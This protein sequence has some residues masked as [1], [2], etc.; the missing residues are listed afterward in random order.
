MDDQRPSTPSTRRPEAKTAPGRPAPSPVGA[1][2][3]RLLVQVDRAV[4]EG[5]LLVVAGAGFGKTELLAQWFQTRPTTGVMWLA[6]GDPTP[7]ASWSGAVVVDCGAEPA[8]GGL[9]DHDRLWRL[10]VLS[11][12]EPVQDL[13]LSRLNGRVAL[14]DARG[15]RMDAKEVADA[16]PWVG[17]AGVGRIMQLTGGWPLAVEALARRLPRDDPEGRRTEAVLRD[18][19]SVLADYCERQVFSELSALDRDRLARLSIATEVDEALAGLLVGDGE[20]AATIALGVRIGLLSRAPDRIARWR[21]AHPLIASQLQALARERRPE[22]LLE[23]HGAA[24]TWLAQRGEDEAAIRHAFEARD[25]ALLADL[26]ERAG[27]WRLAIDWR[28][29]QFRR[30]WLQ[31]ILDTLPDGL[32]ET[33]PGLRLARIMAR[34][35]SGEA[36]LAREDYERLA[37][38]S[39]V[40]PEGTFGLDVEIV[41]H[42]IRMLEESPPSDDQKAALERTAQRIPM[43]DG[44]ASATLDNALCLATLQRGEVEEALDAGRRSCRA[45]GWIGSRMNAAVVQ[46]ALGRACSLGAHRMAAIR[47]YQD[48]LATCA[49]ELGEGSDLARC[50][51]VLL[52][53]EA[54]S[55]NQVPEARAHLEGSMSWV[56]AQ[57]PQFHAPAF[58]TSA[59]LAVH[60]GDVEAGA[61]IIDSC[62][63][64]AQRRGLPRLELSAQLC[65]LEQL[66]L[67]GE[68]EAA[69]TLAGRIG[70]DGTCDQTVDRLLAIDARLVA[71]RIDIETDAISTALSHLAVAGDLIAERPAGL[72]QLNHGVLHAI[73]LRAAGDAPAAHAQLDAI[74]PTIAV[75]GLS[76][77]FLDRGALAMAAL[78]DYARLRSVGRPAVNHVLDDFMTGVLADSRRERHEHRSCLDGLPLTEREHQIA[79]CLARGLSNKEIGRSMQISG[80]TVKWHL[81]NL[82]KR[83]DVESRDALVTR[84]NESRVSRARRSVDTGIASFRL[85]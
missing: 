6:P 16:A 44:L 61:H 55:G 63:R 67:I 10:I 70:L 54:F 45:Y 26:L 69:A 56:E 64:A 24:A 18:L 20:G 76:R 29:R 80:N 59:R 83:F 17:S 68:A 33:R 85:H 15:L 84:Y 34:F 28:N 23:R 47:H 27:G 36:R 22:L 8:I 32:F 7:P 3:H 81:K 53:Q 14:L 58:L 2:R 57:E 41:G 51:R 4:A 49:S 73:A 42:L 72:V 78:R 37:R 31:T 11:R 25:S 40:Q 21:Q 74:L 39:A 65:W 48:A 77:L 30:D 50:A 62:I 82:F 9:G 52:A 43:S 35:C 12:V 60:E 79:D 13:S 46:M 19:T 66:C 75:E 1:A 71:A 5:D 38:T